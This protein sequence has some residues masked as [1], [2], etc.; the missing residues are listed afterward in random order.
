MFTALSLSLS[1]SPQASVAPHISFNEFQRTCLPGPKGTLQLT[2]FHDKFLFWQETYY[3]LTTVCQSEKMRSSL[4]LC[5]KSFRKT[6]AK[7]IELN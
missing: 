1:F 7:I 6:G 3:H 4:Q 2:D 5:A